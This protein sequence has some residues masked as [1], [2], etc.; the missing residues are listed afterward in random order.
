MILKEKKKKLNDT[1]LIFYA[2]IGLAYLKNIDMFT[3]HQNTRMWVFLDEALEK[4]K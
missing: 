3:V 1:I 4:L 2:I